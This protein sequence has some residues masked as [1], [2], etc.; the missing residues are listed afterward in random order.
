MTADIERA[1]K[2]KKYVLH[3]VMSESKETRK[4]RSERFDIIVKLDSD[5]FLVNNSCRRYSVV[6]NRKTCGR[7]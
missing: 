5:N 3:G 6:E 7:A 2:T 1:M 4:Q